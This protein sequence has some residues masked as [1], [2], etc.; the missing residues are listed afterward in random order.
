MLRC[1]VAGMIPIL[2][3]EKYADLH[4]NIFVNSRSYF[5]SILKSES[6]YILRYLPADIA[7]ELAQT[8]ITEVLKK[9][10]KTGLWKIK[11]AERITY[12]IYAA[13]KHIGILD[14]VLSS[15]LLKYDTLAGIADNYDYYSLLIKKNVFGKLTEKDVKMMEAHINKII[16]SQESDGSWGNTVIETSVNLEMLTELGVASDD[17]SISLGC[18]YLF[19]NLNSDFPAHHVG[20][21]YGFNAQYMFSGK[22]RGR[23]FEAAQKLRP[24]WIPRAVCFHHLG[25]IQNSVALITL[26]RLGFE[27]NDSVSHAVDNLYYIY[28]EYHGFCDSDIKKKYVSDNGIRL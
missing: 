2:M 28:C 15:G 18:K 13:L 20:S 12:D 25:V 27:K 9:Q 6:Y 3:S 23:E 4:A 21:P 17:T 11:D 19:S 5:D 24:E 22:D 7:R 14:K 26:L 1:T 10:R 16:D 8:H